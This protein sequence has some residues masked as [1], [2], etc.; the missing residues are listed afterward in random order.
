MA[1]LFK[2]L[3]RRDGL[4]HGHAVRC[5]CRLLLLLLVKLHERGQVKAL[6]RK[7]LAGAAAL[8]R[9]RLGWLR[10]Y[11]HLCQIQLQLIEAAL[12]SSP[13][14]FVSGSCELFKLIF[15]LRGACLL[16]SHV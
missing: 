8:D 12:T 5:T 9:R 3:F 6:Y 14:T 15:A 16:L 11:E 7:H 13:D 2:G 10:V 1:C 4:R